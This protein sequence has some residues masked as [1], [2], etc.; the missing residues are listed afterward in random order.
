MLDTDHYGI[1]CQKCIHGNACKSV[2]CFKWLKELYDP[3]LLGA[4]ASSGF[5]VAAA[6]MDHNSRLT[7]IKHKHDWLLEVFHRTYQRLIG[8]EIIEI[9]LGGGSAV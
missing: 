8:Y 2:D 6:T 1:K 3:R 4:L 9:V 5:D 7:E